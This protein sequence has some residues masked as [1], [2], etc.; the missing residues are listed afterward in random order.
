MV[1]FHS[2]ENDGDSNSIL[3]QTGWSDVDVCFA[4]CLIHGLE[5]LMNTMK[6]IDLEEFYNIVFGTLEHFTGDT[7]VFLE[8]MRACL[9]PASGCWGTTKDVAY[10]FHEVLE[11][12]IFDSPK[13][14]L[15]RDCNLFLRRIE[16]VE[17]AKLENGMNF[18]VEVRKLYQPWS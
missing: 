7:G 6:D 1:F 2:W 8:D 11:D 5:P 12:Q 18:P 10:S 15:Y 3:V 16:S 14:D 9:W 17:V 4:L 13:C